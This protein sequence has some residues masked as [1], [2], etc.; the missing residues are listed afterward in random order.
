MAFHAPSAPGCTS[1]H[2]QNPKQKGDG[3]HRDEHEDVVIRTDVGLPPRNLAQ[4]HRALSRTQDGVTDHIPAERRG[5]LAALSDADA[6][7]VRAYLAERLQ[8]SK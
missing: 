2:G 8:A 4:L 6:A 1:Q 7:R 5:V 3:G